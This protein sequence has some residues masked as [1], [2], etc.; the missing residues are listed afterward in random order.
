MSMAE[1]MGSLP[2]E[3]FTDSNI[4]LVYEQENTLLSSKIH[5][6]I[7]SQV[8][9]FK[10]ESSGRILIEE[11]YQVT[12]TSRTLILPF[13]SWSEDKGLTIS[14]EPL[15]ERRSDLQGLVLRGQTLPEPPYTEVE[16]KNGQVAHIGGIMG[17]MWHLV[18]EP[19]LNFTTDLVQPKDREFGVPRENAEEGWT[20]IVG[21]LM[22]D[23]ADVGVSNFYIT[24]GRSKVVAFSPGIME[25]VTRFFY[26][27]LVAMIRTS[28]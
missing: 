13:G 6:P 22:N 5:F 15:E 3:A 2:L 12:R 7:D 27:C 10:E 16:T 9:I 11:V 24:A 25:G 14:E 28:S 1:F 17:E 18:L 23:E 19:R 20:G 21:A 8:Y 26:K 4:W